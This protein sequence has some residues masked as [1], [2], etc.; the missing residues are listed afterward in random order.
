[1]GRVIKSESSRLVCEHTHTRTSYNMWACGGSFTLR[2]KPCPGSRS[3]RRLT[4][5]TSKFMRM[6]V[7]TLLKLDHVG[8][9]LKDELVQNENGGCGVRWMDELKVKWKS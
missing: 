6:Y 2:N 9:S 8:D 4:L 5:Y 1:M 7:F 3:S